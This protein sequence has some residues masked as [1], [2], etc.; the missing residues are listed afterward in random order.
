MLIYKELKTDFQWHQVHLKFYANPPSDY[1]VT[2]EPTHAQDV[3]VLLCSVSCE[4]RSAPSYIT[5]VD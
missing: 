1:N 4:A 3:R 2:A 5:A